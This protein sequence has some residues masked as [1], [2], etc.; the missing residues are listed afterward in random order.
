MST[1]SSP[2]TSATA[3]AP[4]FS[5]HAAARLSEKIYA[6]LKIL[7]VVQA[8]EECGEIGEDALSGIGLS[9]AQLR[10]PNVKTSVRQLVAVVR[11][12]VRMCRDTRLGL[13]AGQRMHVSSY[14]LYGYA[15]LCADTMRQGFVMALRYQDL[16]TPVMPVSLL[17]EGS[18]VIWQLPTPADIAV[19]GLSADE[20]ACF[21]DMQ[22]AI[23]VTLIKDVMG[24]WCVP[25]EA[26]YALPAPLHAEALARG[27]ECPMRFDHA[28]N[29][30]H[31][32]REWLDRAPQMANPITAAQMSETC[33]R[34]LAQISWQAG[35]TRRVYE[36][37][38]RTPGRFASIESVASSLCM[39]SRTLRRRL[40]AEGT[41]FSDLLARVRYA[42]AQ[43]YLRTT[44]LSIEDIAAALG[45]S[46][47][48]SFRH[49]FKRWSGKSPLA[50][51]ANGG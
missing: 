13:M 5:A 49:A 36:E 17:E 27:L 10:D 34:L 23:T 32:P 39:T 19:L 46:D 51:R 11:N 1:G 50:C 45:F 12:A 30:L 18:R 2:G 6:P 28:V 40:S 35:L 22:F 42:L 44:E 33:E 15:M 20:Y 9:A 37:L 16:G 43:D 25:A 38:T 8:L 26:H 48:S 3:A 4:R 29:Q 24:P 41:S 21:L 47:A 7:S 14:G 31:Y